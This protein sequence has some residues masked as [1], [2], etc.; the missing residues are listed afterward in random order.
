MAEAWEPSPEE[1]H[2][3]I[4]QRAKSR[5]F[6]A[7]TAPTVDQVE[8]LIANTVTDIKT[9][10]GV[11]EPIPVEHHPLARLATVYGTAAEIE[12]ALFPEQARREGSTY[13]VLTE[14]YIDYRDRLASVV[15][16]LLGIAGDETSGPFGKP[17]GHFPVPQRGSGEEGFTPIGTMG[18]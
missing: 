13:E 18:F 7:D 2:A 3:V 17:S 4:P 6:S 1:V 11:D 16:D 15:G 12:R 8:L 10:V 9:Y 14:L 5:P